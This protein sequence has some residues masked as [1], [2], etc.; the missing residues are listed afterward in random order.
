M[1]VIDTWL[2]YAVL[3][4]PGSFWLAYIVVAAIVT[5]IAGVVGWRYGRWYLGP[6][7]LLLAVA[8][9]FWDTPLVLHRLHEDCA[10]DAGFH[11]YK[12][13][14]Q[15]KR[16]HPGVAERLEPLRNPP[17]ER[18]GNMTRVP[19]NERFVWEMERTEDWLGIERRRERIVDRESGEVLAEYIDYSSE[20]DSWGK[21]N[22]VNPRELRFWLMQRSCEGSTMPQQVQFNGYQQAIESL[23]RE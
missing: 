2:A 20:K 13:L 19:L 10:R 14:E 21:V 6:V 9:M 5:L 1:K 3:T 15:W 8:Y 17:W 7:V 4:W 16:E 12:D 23:G 11:L 18:V 22:W